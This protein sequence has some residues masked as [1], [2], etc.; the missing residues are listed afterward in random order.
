MYFPGDVAAMLSDVAGAGLPSVVVPADGTVFSLTAVATIGTGSGVTAGA[1][2]ALATCRAS[3]STGPSARTAGDRIAKVG[4]AEPSVTIAK[5]VAPATVAAGS[6]ATF[7]IT[8]SNA[9]SSPDAPVATAYDVAVVDTLPPELTPVTAGGAAL[10]DG[11]TTASGLRWRTADRTLTATVASLDPGA[12]TTFAVRA[13]L[14]SD[15]AAA[16][17]FTNNV[18][19]TATSLPGSSRPERTSPAVSASATLNSAASSPTITKTAD[20]DTVVLGNII[21]YTV[22]VTLPPNS[23]YEN[24]TLLDVLPHGMG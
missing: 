7:T 18:T 9:A 8:V 6:P 10:A 2:I 14:A 17:T 23:R 19:A 21:S 13:K 4:V 15:A 11:D 1:N 3:M 20:R 12:T 24:V 5:S 22:T 16:S